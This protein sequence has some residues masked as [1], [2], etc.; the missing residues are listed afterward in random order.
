MCVR[1]GWPIP[2]KQVT[3][4]APPYY[5]RRDKVRWNKVRW[6]RCVECGQAVRVTGLKSRPRMRVHNAANY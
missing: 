2:I 1:S 6:T 3:L 5:A 4:E